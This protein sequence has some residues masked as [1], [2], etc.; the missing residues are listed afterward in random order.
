MGEQGLNLL[1]NNAG[2]SPKSGRINF[3]TSE[4]MAQTFAINTISPLMLTKAFLPL[5]KAGSSSTEVEEDYFIKNAT[6]VNISSVLGSIGSNIGE[7][8]GGLYPYR[9]SKVRLGNLYMYLNMHFQ[10][11]YYRQ[12]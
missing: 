7:R 4:Q 11:Q 3:T 2:Y 10:Y 12:H 1:I 5:L 6:V 8:S 9:C